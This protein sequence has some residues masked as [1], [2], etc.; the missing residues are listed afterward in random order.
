MRLFYLE[1]RKKIYYVRF[2]NPLTGERMSGK[3]TGESDYDK[4]Y[5]IASKWYHDGIPDEKTGKAVAISEFFTFDDLIFKIK[6]TKLSSEQIEYITK[7][8]KNRKQAYEEDEKELI[9]CLYE[10]W[11]YETSEYVSDKI[12]YG[13]KISKRQ[14]LDRSAAVKNHWQPYFKHTKLSELTS[15][16][17]KN[18]GKYLTK[19]HKKDQKG[20]DLDELL[21][22]KTVNGIL[23]AGTTFLRWAYN[24]GI[25]QNNVLS[26]YKAFSVKK[27]TDEKPRGILTEKEAK[28]LFSIEWDNETSKLANELASISA[29]RSAEVRALKVKI[30]QRGYLKVNVAW[31]KIEKGIKKTKTE[32]E[33]IIPIPLGLKNR[34]IS[35]SRSNPLGFS[36]DNFVFYSPVY[37]DQPL[38]ENV[39][40]KA[41]KKHLLKIGIDKEEQKERN[42]VFHSWRHY[43]AK[44]LDKILGRRGAMRVT[45]HKDHTVFDRYADHIDSDDMKEI[46]D[47]ISKISGNIL[48]F[49]EKKDNA[50]SI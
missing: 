49:D 29:M 6:S 1:K 10:F 27:K 13:E 44:H 30:V 20:N 38:S 25:L 19:K 5:F 32:D 33:R 14:C 8:L 11:N 37:P 28:E 26:D 45:G 22:R 48:S 31:G 35:L 17:I 2:K 43:A 36:P 21:S 9:E 40:N 34:L 18:F 7:L 41:L 23:F 47:G 42:I 16:K 50:A 24:K 39:F 4:A 46:A 3:S 12:Y 15:E